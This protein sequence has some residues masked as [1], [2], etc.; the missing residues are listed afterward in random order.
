MLLS[1]GMEKK[2]SKVPL[3]V[4]WV[5]LIFILLDAFVLG[6]QAVEKKVQLK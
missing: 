4:L 3:L 6:V 2:I 5:L 1:H